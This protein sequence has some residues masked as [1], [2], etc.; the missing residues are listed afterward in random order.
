MALGWG[1]ALG[2]I[3]DWIPGRK[4]SKENQIQ[5]LLN[6]SSKLAKEIPL[7]ATSAQRISDNASTIKRLRQELSRIA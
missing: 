2:K 1:S 6:E 3:F 4:E 5:R 7:S